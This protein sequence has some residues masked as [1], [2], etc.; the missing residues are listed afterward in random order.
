[1]HVARHPPAGNFLDGVLVLLDLV[2]DLDPLLQDRITP[3]ANQ[4]ARPISLLSCSLQ[5]HLGERTN[6]VDLRG[7]TQAIPIPP[8][9]ASIRLYAQEQAAAIPERV[10]LGLGLRRLDLAYC[11]EIESHVYNAL[12]GNRY[13]HDYTLL[14]WLGLDNDRTLQTI[15]H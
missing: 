6:R 11:E 14:Q 13:S 10:G 3:L 7:V 4:I 2:G 8:E 5:S 12:Q 15:N 1:M 9:L